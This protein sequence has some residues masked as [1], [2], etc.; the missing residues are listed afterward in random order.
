[1]GK[2]AM[3][4][5][6]I[7]SPESTP[8]VHHPTHPAFQDQVP[9]VFGVVE[10]DVGPRILANIKRCAG[11]LPLVEHVVSGRFNGRA[12]IL[13]MIR[14]HPATRVRWTINPGP[15]TMLEHACLGVRARH[16]R[17]MTAWPRPQR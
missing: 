14:V 17:E 8:L 12:A 6:L 11:Q 15:A 7:P 4:M 13:E 9:Y 1:V 10:L 16:E 2:F 3:D 5:V